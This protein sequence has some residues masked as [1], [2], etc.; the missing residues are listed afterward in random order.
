MELPGK[1]KVISPAWD[2]P[3]PQIERDAFVQNT[4]LYLPFFRF[5]LPLIQVLLHVSRGD[6]LVVKIRYSSLP[7]PDCLNV[8]SHYS[9]EDSIA[10]G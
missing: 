9:S 4:E 2:A 1:T 5:A 7:R 6:I 10:V 3:P 8:F